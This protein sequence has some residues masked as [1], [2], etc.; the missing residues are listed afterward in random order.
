MQKCPRNAPSWGILLFAMIG[1]KSKRNINSAETESVVTELTLWF[2]MLQIGW[3][4]LM[5]NTGGF[6]AL[7][8]VTIRESRI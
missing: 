5:P 6:G 2:W 1:G 7:S 3:I 8:I 4:M